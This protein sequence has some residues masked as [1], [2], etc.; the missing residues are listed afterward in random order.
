MQ[1]SH[2]QLLKKIEEETKKARQ[3]ENSEA[4]YQHLYT[5]KTLCEVMLDSRLKPAAFM[6]E[7][8]PPVGSSEGSALPLRGNKLETDDGANGDSIFDF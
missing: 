3:E 4:L 5:I 8:S 7:D 6:V 1:I 2:H